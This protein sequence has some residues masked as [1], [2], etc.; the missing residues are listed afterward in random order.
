MTKDRAT[1]NSNAAWLEN[2][3]PPSVLAWLL[4]PFLTVILFWL[5]LRAKL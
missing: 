3:Y 1:L 5:T 4:F 2:T